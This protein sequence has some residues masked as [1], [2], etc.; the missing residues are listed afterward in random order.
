ML[1]AIVK[2]YHIDRLSPIIFLVLIFKQQCI[3][4][5][6]GANTS[7][8]NNDRPHDFLNIISTNINIRVGRVLVNDTTSSGRKSIQLVFRY[9]IENK[10]LRRRNLMLSMNDSD[11]SHTNRQLMVSVNRSVWAQHQV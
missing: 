5:K 3:R 2:R 8:V 1:N 11:C 4:R 9:V 10:F 7:F 6:F